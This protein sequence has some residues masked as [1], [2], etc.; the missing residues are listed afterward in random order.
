[1]TDKPT[2]SIIPFPSQKLYTF[3]PS[4]RGYQ[5]LYH[6]ASTPCPGCGRH[7]WY[8]GRLMAEC[9]FCTTAIPIRS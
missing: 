2:A 8:V 9:A 5:P 1:M 7:H 3:D 4:C 6:G